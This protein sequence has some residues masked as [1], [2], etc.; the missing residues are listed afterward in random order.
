MKASFDNMQNNARHILGEEV[1]LLTP[2]VVVVEPSGFCNLKCVFC[3]LNDAEASKGLKR[4]FL[5][6]ELYRQILEQI[7]EFPAPIKILRLIGNGEP[8][9][10]KD[11]VSMVSLAKKAG[12]AEKVEITT[13]G[14][15]LNPK[16]NR[17]LVHAGLDIL[18]VSV[19]ALREEDFLSIAGCRMDMEKFTENLKDFFGIRNGCQMYI[20]ITNLAIKSEED[21]ETFFSTY[22]DFADHIFIE[23]ISPVWPEFNM[24]FEWSQEM[25]RYGHEVKRKEICAHIFKSIMVC[26]DGMV[27]PCCADWQRKLALG[28]IRNE[29]LRSIW[30]GSKLRDLQRMFLRHRREELDPCCRCLYNEYCDPDSLDG[31]EEEIAQRM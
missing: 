4:D 17:D 25:G 16:L 27:L 19:E 30:N 12:V 3:P 6:L 7:Q 24:D 1:P 20:K 21:R 10:N 31:F 23:N 22:G 26:A 9:L 28:N 14:T 29:R 5:A 18:K 11:I 13:N 2:Y 8:L 15:L